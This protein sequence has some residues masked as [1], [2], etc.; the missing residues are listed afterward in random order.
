LSLTPDSPR[1]YPSHPVVGVGAV[2]LVRDGRIVLVRRSQAPLS[3]TWSLPGGV[4]ELGESLTDGIAREIREETG[5]HVEVGPLLE[6][7][8]H[9]TRDEEGRVRYHYVIADYLCWARTGL[10]KAGSDAAEI[11]LADP[12]DLDR[13]ALTEKAIAVIG[14]ARQ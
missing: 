11:A 5:L 2:V 1:A 14:K 6:I 4:L 7:F 8:E 12:S 9:I 3:G 10:P 13:F